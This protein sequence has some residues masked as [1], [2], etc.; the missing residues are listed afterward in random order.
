M[1]SG[2]VM[3][4]GRSNVGKSTL[5]NALV[6]SKVAIMSPKPQTTRHPVR[7]VLHDP[8]GQIVFVDTPGVFLGK[9]D[10]VSRRLND[11]VK[12][13]LVG[14]DAILYVVDPTRAPGAEEEF[15]Q[16]LL[17]NAGKPLL[18]LINKGDLSEKERPHLEHYRAVD[19]GQQGS[20]D[21]SAKTHKN[22]NLV[23]DK[24]FE[25]LPEGEPYYPDLQITDMAH[26]EWLE[27]LIREK[28]FHALHEELPYSV[29]VNVEDM[30]ERE[31]GSRFIQATI[32]TTADRY[33]GMIIGKG[34][35]RLKEI[36]MN[37][38]KELE[39]VTGGKVFLEL[40]VK[41]DEK[42]QTRFQ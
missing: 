28:C 17:K 38:R 30:E 16:S 9:K 21:V 15:I 6:G 40:T 39:T 42:W 25:L 3:L 26:K 36:G 7:G 1:K 4:A 22:L 20:A 24:L 23:V 29:R 35:I 11:L 8:R 33:K 27:E 32:L 10:G 18:Y 2:F 12:E 5:L 13:T 14:I 31:D 19:V 41:V 37:A 34:G